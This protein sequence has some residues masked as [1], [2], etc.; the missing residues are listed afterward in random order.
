MNAST[1]KKLYGAVTEYFAQAMPDAETEL[2]FS[3]VYELIVA[4]ILSAQCTDKRVNSITPA[5][6]R[7]YP[8]V[9]SMADATADEILEY[10]RSCS[11]PNSKSRHLAA[12]A[13]MVRDEFGG[14]I[15]SDIDQMQRLPGVGRKTANVV[16]SVA[17]G[18]A[19]MPV[20]THVFRVA[21]RIGLTQGSKSPLD[22]ERQLTAN[23]APEVLSRA[24]HWLI[25]HG[26]YVCTARS[27]KCYNCGLNAICLYKQK[28]M[29]PKASKTT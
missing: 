15:P 5:L 29:Q 17:F 9:E 23:F 13:R 22:T 16:A 19:A 10:I 26:R 21:E 25:L 12:M 6:F 20:D 3:S 8:T 1:R 2:H 11:Y 18:K 7:R 28:N 27:P 24:H 14:V 4:V